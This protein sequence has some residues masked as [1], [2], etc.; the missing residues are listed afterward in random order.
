MFP[1]ISCERIESFF[2]P[3]T[4]GVLIEG[5]GTGN[6]PSNRTILINILREALKNEILIVTVTQCY[7]GSVSASYETEQVFEDIGVIP[8]NDM[9]T[10][11]ALAKLS[12]VLALPD[13]TFQ[14]RVE[15]MKTD[16]KGEMTTISCMGIC[17]ESS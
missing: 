13:L 14:K 9:T 5:Y 10:E 17:S 3:S 11:A 15:I 2:K 16:I 6:L 4:K 1:T 12:H 8:G 7:K